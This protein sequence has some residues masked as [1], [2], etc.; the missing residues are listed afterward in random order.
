M[1]LFIMIDCK[2]AAVERPLSILYMES[3][4]DYWEETTV[5]HAAYGCYLY[6]KNFVSSVGYEILVMDEKTA[7]CVVK[8]EMRLKDACACIIN[9]GL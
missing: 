8:Y 6:G 7:G 4:Y 9:E 1:V 3:I 2:S 5:L